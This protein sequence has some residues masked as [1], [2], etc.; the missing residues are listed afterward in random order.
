MADIIQEWKKITAVD[1]QKYLRFFRNSR[2][3]TEMPKILHWHEEAFKK[4]NCLSC[5]NCCRTTPALV[6]RSDIERIAGFLKMKP[7]EFVHTYVL[8]DINGELSLNS[9]PCRF[10][11][12]DNTC[13]IYEVRPLACRQ[14]PHTD[15]PEYFKRPVLNANNVIV[16]PAAYYIAE[17]LMASIP[18]NKP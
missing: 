15:D 11:N 16:C 1:K 9:V 8:E 4:V 13:R 14:F 2:L 17:K 6:N 12:P 5:A 18:D 3:K 10:L 7:R